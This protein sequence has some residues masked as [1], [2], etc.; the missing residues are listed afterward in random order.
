MTIEQCNVR[1]GLAEAASPRVEV[2]PAVLFEQ[3][4]EPGIR[5]NDLRMMPDENEPLR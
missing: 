2:R 3:R 4:Y 5:R 1:T